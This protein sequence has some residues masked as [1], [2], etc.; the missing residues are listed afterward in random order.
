MI[1]P[2]DRLALPAGVE[3]RDDALHD[4]VRACSI[5]VNRT[6]L[7]VIGASTPQEAAAELVRCYD[8]EA[9][10]ALDDVLRF[11]TELN[12]RLLLNVAAHGG[13]VALV[14]RWLRRVPFLLPFGVLPSAPTARRPVD[15]TRAGS[16]VR[17]APNALGPFVALLL[18]SGTFVPALL[19]A[20][21]GIVEPT[22]AGALGGAIAGTVLVH[23]LA[24]LAALRG[25]PACVVTQG[26]RIAVVHGAISRRRTRGVAACGPATGLVL[27]ACLLAAL[28]VVPSIELGATALVS[29]LNAFGLTVLSSDGRT[30]CGLG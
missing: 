27:A 20:A 13:R 11:C 18:V 8:V 17:S 2:L 4:V 22:L 15:T 6:G 23:E 3:L 16:L 21:V 1:G 5:P 24:H 30:L 26:F 10:T 14:H 7:A 12:A 19:L 9:R 28:W 29:L 25:V